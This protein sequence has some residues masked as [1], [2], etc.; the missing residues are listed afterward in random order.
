VVKHNFRQQQVRISKLRGSN[1][2]L[3]SS[4]HQIFALGFV[5]QSLL[6]TER[7]AK[8]D[9]LQTVADEMTNS[10]VIPQPCA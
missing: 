2:I 3:E 10:N 6:D 4:L 9:L 8:V 7:F 1:H 5:C